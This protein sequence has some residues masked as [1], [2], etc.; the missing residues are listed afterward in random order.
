MP[1]LSES[2]RHSASTL[3]SLINVIGVDA[4]ALVTGALVNDRV[5]RCT[6]P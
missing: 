2:L 3:L 4:A 5:I 6:S 1:G